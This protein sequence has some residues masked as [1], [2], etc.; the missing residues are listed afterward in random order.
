MPEFETPKPL[1]MAKFWARI[2][3]DAIPVEFDLDMEEF[4]VFGLS[5]EEWAKYLEVLDAAKASTV[6]ELEARLNAKGLAWTYE[7]GRGWE[8]HQIE[9]TSD[10]NVWIYD[11]GLTL[12]LPENEV[13]DPFAVCVKDKGFGSGEG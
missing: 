8:R 4:P 5:P 1:D 7:T 3:K 2:N 13:Y 9:L 12:L 6:E 10:R 11:R